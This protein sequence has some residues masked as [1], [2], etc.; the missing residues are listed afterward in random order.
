MLGT[1]HRAT[2]NQN[3]HP[4]VTWGEGSHGIGG[5]RDWRLR[6]KPVGKLG[7]F[8]CGLRQGWRSAEPTLRRWHFVPFL[9]A[10]HQHRAV[11]KP[12]RSWGSCACR[13]NTQQMCKHLNP[14]D[15]FKEAPSTEPE[16]LP[17]DMVWKQLEPRRGL[18]GNRGQWGGSPGPDTAGAQ[19]E[20]L[21]LGWRGRRAKGSLQSREVW[22]SGRISQPGYRAWD[23]E[24]GVCPQ[25]TARTGLSGCPDGT[26]L[27][28][29]PSMGW[30]YHRASSERRDPVR[31]GKEGCPPKAHSCCL[32]LG[33]RPASQACD[34][35]GARDTPSKGPQ[36]WMNPSL[37]HLETLNKD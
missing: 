27:L 16:T 15:G 3:L 9:Y 36:T 17:R 11:H 18:S 5:R 19:G 24:T 32:G 8:R 30:L 7:D 37:S 13:G 28:S 22:D 31:A 20:P 35:A 26:V 21:E 12:L 1:G 10:G 4:R 25:V 29:T 2:K 14:G 33:T 34:H 23:C 6:C